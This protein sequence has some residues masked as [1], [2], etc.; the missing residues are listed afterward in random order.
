M[1]TK[2]RDL[3]AKDKRDVVYGDESIPTSHATSNDTSDTSGDVINENIPPTSTSN[4]RKNTRGKEED[5]ISSKRLKTIEKRYSEM[6]KILIDFDVSHERKEIVK[7]KCNEISLVSIKSIVTQYLKDPTGQNCIDDIK[8]PKGGRAEYNFKVKAI[9]LRSNASPFTQYQFKTI[10][11]NS[12][13]FNPNHYQPDY[14]EG[15]K[16]CVNVDKQHNEIADDDENLLLLEESYK[17]ETKQK[18][19]GLC[20]KLMVEAKVS[21]E[22]I[23]ECMKD[24]EA[25]CI[26]KGNEMELAKIET[27]M[28]QCLAYTFFPFKRVHSKSVISLCPSKTDDCICLNFE[29]CSGSY[30]PSEIPIEPR[31]FIPEN[32]FRSELPMTVVGGQID[33]GQLDV[34]NDEEI[35][36][37]ED[38]LYDQEFNEV[39]KLVDD[40]TKEYIGI[41]ENVE[42]DSGDFADEFQNLC[43]KEFDQ[44]KATTEFV[45]TVELPEKLDPHRQTIKAYLNEMS[46]C[47]GDVEHKSSKPRADFKSNNEQ[48]MKRFEEIGLPPLKN[49]SYPYEQSLKTIKLIA[50]NL[51]EIHHYGDYVEKSANRSISEDFYNEF[52]ARGYQYKKVEEIKNI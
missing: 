34:E 3:S 45:D 40:V 51:Y 26:V 6:E 31:P 5:E 22:R 1:T 14:E 24:A 30:S 35:G 29:H 18:A 4:K 9:H 25:C 7:Q 33:E 50:T 52:F 38:L 44:L 2:G 32:P 20:K 43:N 11:G 48:F 28:R 46:M 16:V 49:Y 17:D 15:R 8:L 42:K 13:C 47:G 36:E 39:A 21:A 27:V 12:I 23:L 41:S 37:L 19:V 10:C